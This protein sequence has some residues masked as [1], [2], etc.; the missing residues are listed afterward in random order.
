[1]LTVL[2]SAVSERELSEVRWFCLVNEQMSEGTLGAHSGK[3]SKGCV[4]GNVERTVGK[5]VRAK[6]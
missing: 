4:S 2:E 1:M 6:L 3:H 5:Y